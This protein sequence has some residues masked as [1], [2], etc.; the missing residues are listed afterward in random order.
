MVTSDLAWI[1]PI[2]GSGFRAA[3]VVES[4]DVSRVVRPM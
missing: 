4:Y 2:L 3:G 1:L